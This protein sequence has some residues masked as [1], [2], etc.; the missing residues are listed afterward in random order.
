MTVVHLVDAHYCTESSKFI[1]AVLLSLSAMTRLELPH[2]NVLSKVDLIE[3]YGA[4]GKRFLTRLHNQIKISSYLKQS[5]AFNLDFYTEVLDLRH[6]LEQLEGE[7]QELEVSIGTKRNHR[8]KERFAK[9]N[10][11]LIDVIEDYSLVNFVPLNIEDAETMKRVVAVI[12]KA[13]GYL[14]GDLEG[15]VQASNSIFNSI[16]HD[17]ALQYE[18]VGEIQEKYMTKSDIPIQEQLEAC[19]QE[20]AAAR[21]D[22]QSK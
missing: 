11:V 19:I 7:E 21:S 6:L 14:F 22:P 2:V 1:S 5:I 3:K 12:D 13:N 8:L 18:R 15:T 17:T 9:M 10:S 16:S 20:Q 4:L